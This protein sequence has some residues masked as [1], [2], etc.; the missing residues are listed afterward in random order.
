MQEPSNYVSILKQPN[1]KNYGI[2]S[3]SLARDEYIQASTINKELYKVLYDIFTLKNNIIGRFTGFYDKGVFTLTDSGYNYNIDFLNI[4]DQEFTDGFL[5]TPNIE[6]YFISENEKSILGVVNRA[7]NSIYDL[8]IKL[9]ESTQVD[10]GYD[11]IPA[12]N[13]E[14]TVILGE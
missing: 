6:K 7:I 10:R 11:L 14:S 9:F 5:N 3:F 13:N 8:Q 1:F 2:N 4:T 12:F